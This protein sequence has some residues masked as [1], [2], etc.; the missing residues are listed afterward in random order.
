MATNWMM[1]IQHKILTMVMMNKATNWGVV[2]VVIAIVMGLFAAVETQGYAES[3]QCSAFPAT[4]AT[5]R[6]VGASYLGTS[7]NKETI[8]V[9]NAAGFPVVVVVT[10]PNN[11][12]RLSATAI[13]PNEVVVLP[14]PVGEY[15]ATILAG[16]NWCNL[17]SGFINGK[18]NRLSGV[19]TIKPNTIAMLTISP[20]G[21]SA[22]YGVRGSVNY[23]GVQSVINDGQRTVLTTQLGRDG[24]YHLAGKIN[25]E[26]VNFLVDTGA[27]Y[28]AVSAVQARHL[29]LTGCEKM[30]SVTV[31]GVTNGCLSKAKSLTLGELVFSDVDVYVVDNTT[32]EHVLLG[33][34]IIKMFKLEQ[35][36]GVM[37]L[38]IAKSQPQT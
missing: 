18:T 3:M 13:N 19:L 29:M 1:A 31:N 8:Q 36:E 22:G 5:H 14:V 2:T 23:K 34:N 17:T 15:G 30:D 28:V 6:Y 7:S 27:S 33:M 35:A 9:K 37:R 25:G 4:G 21:E 32:H 20:Y 10:T 11:V 12:T 38:S 24:H 26:A 16:D